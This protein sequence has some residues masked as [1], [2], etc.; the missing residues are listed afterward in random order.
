MDADRCTMHQCGDRASF[1]F[2][3]RRF[4][5]RYLRKTCPGE[6][7]PYSAITGRRR[8]LDELNLLRYCVIIL[9]GGAGLTFRR[10]RPRSPSGGNLY[11]CAWQARAAKDTGYELAAGGGERV[12]GGLTAP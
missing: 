4:Q 2:A 1:A 11:P 12:L 3:S 5:G 10:R 7:V 6:E 9:E 8:Q